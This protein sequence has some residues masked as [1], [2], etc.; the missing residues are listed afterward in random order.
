[1]QDLQNAITEKFQQIASSGAIDAMIEKQLTETIQTI[2]KDSLRSH[3]DFG[4]ALEEHVKKAV[5]VDLHRLELPGYNDL[6]LKLIQQQV[7]VQLDN[8]IAVQIEKQMS[9]LLA[10]PPAEMRLS[11]LLKE[12]IESKSNDS[13]C[14][15]DGPERIS[16][17]IEKHPDG[18]AH[19]YFDEDEGKEKYSCGYAI[20]IASG[21]RVYS[22]K[23][24]EQDISKKL[25]IGPFYNYERRLFQLYAAGTKL[26][27]DGENEYDFDTQYPGRDY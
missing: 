14:V 2:I 19:V 11:E 15:C 3:S 24:D 6:I 27:I 8:Q 16:L 23:I 4:R 25:F 26:I 13:S 1:M 21:G 18:Y 20:H 22:L 12:F 10:P 5:N 17:H 7:A 9:E